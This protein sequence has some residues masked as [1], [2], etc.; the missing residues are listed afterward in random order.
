MMEYSMSIVLKGEFNSPME[1]NSMA[2][3][4]R[5]RKT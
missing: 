3:Q 5:G 1:M 2:F 4:A